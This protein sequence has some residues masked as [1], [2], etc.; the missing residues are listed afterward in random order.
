MFAQIDGGQMEL[1]GDGGFVPVLVKAA[2]KQDL[3]TDVD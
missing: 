1:T 3:Q 2:L